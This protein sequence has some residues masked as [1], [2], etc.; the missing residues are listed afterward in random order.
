VTQ[1]DPTIPQ[2]Q[3]GRAY[4]RVVALGAVV[5]IPA[6]VVAALF[7]GLVHEL[8]HWLWTDL[9]DAL[10][11]SGPPWYL[12]LGLPVAGAAIVVAGRALLP[13]DGGHEPLDGLSPDPLPLSHAPAS[14]WRR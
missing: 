1:G 9:P 7:L 3:A 5:G 2:Q 10:G 14:S 4:I 6:A 13:G 12:V 8:Q 11:R